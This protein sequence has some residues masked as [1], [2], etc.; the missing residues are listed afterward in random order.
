IEAARGDWILVLDADERL[1]PEGARELRRAVA[2][3][4]FDCGMLP[5]HNASRIDAPF[6]EVV[7]GRSRIGEVA[8][9]PRLFRRTADLRYSGIVHEN[10]GE[11][12][13][14]GKRRA[15]LLTGIDIVH[16]GVIPD[17]RQRRDK[18][19][20]NVALLERACGLEPQDPCNWG[21]LAFEL[22]ESGDAARAREAADA[23]F[24]ALTAGNPTSDLAA[25]RL[26][27]ARAWLE[28]QSGEVEG[29]RETLAIGVR[30]AGEH[31]DV[32]FILGCIAEIE[33]LKSDALERRHA[34]LL[35]ALGHQ[36]AALACD[37]GLYL[38]KF[39][40]GSSGWAA[41][42]R[43]G[44]ALLLL[45][46]VEES[47]RAFERALAVNP[48]ARE[49]AWGRAE[50]IL[51]GGDPRGALR[52]V[53]PHLDERPDGW[54]IAALAAGVAGSVDAMATWLGRAQSVLPAGFLAPSRRE[55]YADGLA[56]LALLLGRE[57]DAPGPIGVL[58]TLV[59]SN[60][61]TPAK[62]TVRGLEDPLV[63][64]LV[65]GLLRSWLGRGMT[66]KVERLLS[67]QAEASLPGLGAM[68][69]EVVGA[70]EQRERVR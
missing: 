46:R 5:L 35:E 17:I 37:S 67:P 23:G 6:E 7:A 15:R 4:D 50:A 22:L 55:R 59:H 48:N 28:V 68:I 60:A 32:H 26:T 61:S 8:Y 27:V 34:S 54:T 19:R 52:E 33:A 38:Q 44:T 66:D 42:I 70:L 47:R 10:V 63:A 65:R 57:I 12:L 24:G 16:L 49:A 9:L 11:W 1:T 2:R 41:E 36:A 29:A 31:P 3:A 43:Q 53:Q 58:A 51:V 18:S 20:R 25:L 69:A 64:A 62:G 14:R 21:Y 39:I 40:D 56:T 13:F 30:A 45:G